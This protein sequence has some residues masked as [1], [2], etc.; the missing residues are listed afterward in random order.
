MRVLVCLF[1]G[2]VASTIAGNHDKYSGYTVYGVH[3]NDQLH[4]KVLSDLQKDLDLDI[5]RHGV[6]KA[7]DALVMVSPENRLEFLKILEENNMHHYIHLN[8]VA[9]SLKQRDDEFLRWKLS[10]GS[11]LSLFEDYPRYGDIIDYMERIARNNSSIVTVVNAGNSFEG[12]PVKYL[13]IST[14]NFTDT[15]KP[16]YFLEATMHAREWV[17]TQAALYTIHRL[18]EDLKTEDMDLIQG[19]DW[20]IFPVVNPD[21]YEY[22]HT[23]D[24]MWRKTRSFNATISATCYGVD[25]NRNFDIEFNTV[26]VSSDPCSSIYPGHEAFSEPETR[27]VRDILLEYKNRIQVFMDTHSYGNY[28]VYGFDNGTLPQ[29][30]LHIHQVGALMG[31]AIDTLKLQKAPFYIVGNSMYVFYAV[32]GSGQDYAQAVGVGFSYTIELPGYE[33]DF[34]VPPSYINQINTETWEG[35]AASAR[36]ARSYIVYGVKLED[37]VDQEVFYGLQSGLDLDLWEYGVPKVKDALVMV[38]PDKRKRFLDT[39]DRNN[40]KHYLHLSD[41]A[42]ALEDNDDDLSSWGRDSSRVFEKYARYAEIDAYLEEVARTYPQIAT[43]VNAGLSFEGRA[44]KYLKISTSNFT[45]PSKPVYFIDATMHAREWITTPP[46]LFTI[47]RLVEDLREQDRDLLEEIDWIVMPL[48]RLWRRTRSF[49]I[50]RHPECYGVDAN[51]NFDIDFHGLGS[52]TDPCSNT[53]RGHEPFSEPETGYVRDVILE[54]I[55]RMQVYLNVH[56]HGNLILYG[57]GNRTLPSNVVPLHQV[58]A[59]M[60][61]AIDHNKLLEAP[62]YV[63]GNSA[64]VLYISSGSAQDYGQ[65]VGVPFSYTLELPGMGYGFQIPVRYVNQVNMETWE[66]IAASARIAKIYYR[67]RNQ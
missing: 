48:E 19:I 44:V 1:L 21:G 65:A 30:A 55:D 38:S 42:K 36:A 67:A 5:W 51:R 60:G 53:F 8:D 33:Y 10:R 23:T 52:S 43:L 16:I 58:G 18:I 27:Y 35:I 56:S 11:E 32:S 28:I 41:V 13:K 50:T 63:V 7:R 54:H 61:A 26:S 34:R 24:R 57:Y 40:I 64:L 2:L 25:P 31:A 6:P 47:H 15:S 17:T 3:T 62:Y 20:I 46:A 22:S 66:G 59:V 12:R 14:T 49:N 4:Q 37:Q 9:R 29:N 39:L 45:D